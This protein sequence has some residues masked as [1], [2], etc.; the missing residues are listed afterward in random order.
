[1]D[2]ITFTFSD[3]EETVEFFVLEQTKF[4]GHMYLLVTDSD[5]DEDE[6]AQAYIFKDISAMEDKESIYVPVEDEKEL[7]AVSKI[8]EELLEDVEFESAE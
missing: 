5:V 2:K 8:F 1:M 3:T 4:Q 6:D 7:D